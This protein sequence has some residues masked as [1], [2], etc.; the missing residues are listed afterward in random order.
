MC[1]GAI[2]LKI[3]SNSA[4]MAREDTPLRQSLKIVDEEMMGG[5]SLEVLTRFGSADALK[6]PRVLKAADELQR[7]IAANYADKVIKTFYSFRVA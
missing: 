5:M 4:M 6:D 7:H 2:N 1:I 3:D